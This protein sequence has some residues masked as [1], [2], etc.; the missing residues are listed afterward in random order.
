MKVKVRMKVKERG[1]LAFM[2]FGERVR[3]G[4]GW[5]VRNLDV[6]H[7]GEEGLGLF[8]AHDSLLLQRFL[9]YLS[10]KVRARSLPP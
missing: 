9:I 8:R 6:L 4:R 3:G 10:C 1:M 2:L 7:I 5:R